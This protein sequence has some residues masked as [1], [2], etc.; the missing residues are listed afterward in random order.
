MADLRMGGVLGGKGEG[1]VDVGWGGKGGGGG[2]GEERAAEGLV[3]LHC[4]VVLRMGSGRGG[5][6]YGLDFGCCTSRLMVGINFMG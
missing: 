4:L 3:E 1:D 6:G 2:G 5:C